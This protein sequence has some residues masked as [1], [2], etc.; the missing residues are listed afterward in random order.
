MAADPGKYGLACGGEDT[1]AA[2]DDS[3]L[4]CIGRKTYLFVRR[5]MQNPEY[6]EKIQARAAQIR[7]E[8]ENKK[9][10]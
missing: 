8:E 2:M 4:W 5:V 7:A 6:R 10:E 3:A 1:L 9:G